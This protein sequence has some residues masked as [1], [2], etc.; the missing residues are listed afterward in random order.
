M[1]IPI[2]GINIPAPKVKIDKILLEKYADLYRGIRDKKDTVT[3]R[4]LIITIRELLIT[5][6]S[7]HKKTPKRYHKKGRILIKQ[8]VNKTFLEG[9]VPEIEY[10][11][12]IRGA[13]GRGGKD[14]DFLLFSGRHF[15]EPLLW[16]L[17]EHIKSAGKTVAVINP[18]GH[19]G[20]GQTRVIGPFKYFRNIKKII[21]LASTQ[22]K[23]GGSISV[24]TNVVKLLRNNNLAKCVKN[25]EI[26]IPMFGGSRGHRFGQS[27]EVGYE[28]MEAG[29]NAQ[30]LSLITD[31]I[32]TRLRNEKVS[33]PSLRFSSI[34]I[35]NEEYPRKTFNEVGLEFFSIDSSNTLA[36]GITKFLDGKKAKIPLRLV[37]CDTGAIPRT[38]KLANNILFAEKNTHEKI[39]VIY[40]EK[41]RLSAGIV[42][43]TTISKI[44]E[45]KKVKDLIKIKK[46]NIPQK[47][48]FKNTIIIYSD[49][50]IDTGGTAEKDLKFISNLYP[51]C[52]IKIFVATHPVLSKGFGA[53]KRIGADVYILGNTLNWEGLSD[54][55]GIE[56]VDF[57]PE[58]Y[59]F[60]QGRKESNF[61]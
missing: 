38:Q 34:D 14:L 10:A 16:S 1:G 44:E 28:V 15:P 8:L 9:L 57:A 41:K 3:W 42:K 24:L 52:V 29:F 23:L 32:L 47:P 49:D 2:F 56:I 53:I 30:I 11:V 17:A 26:I 61:H 19:Y 58:I 45:W 48:I 37:V 22:S 33:L 51:N 54:V 55:K 31:N 18:V 21:I 13:T 59:N 7:D 40:M 12:G 35:H 50:M 5:E 4:T 36:N 46:V 43:D 20:D 39:Q 6:A 60:L 27:Q 25:V